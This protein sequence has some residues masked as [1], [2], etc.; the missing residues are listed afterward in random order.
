MKGLKRGGVTV[1]MG[2]GAM[3]R[4]HVALAMSYRPRTSPRTRGELYT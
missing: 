1:V 4:M 3:G 2:S